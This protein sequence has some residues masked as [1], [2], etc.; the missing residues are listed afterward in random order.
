MN[1]D[2][3]PPRLFHFSEDPAIRRFDPRPVARPS[4]R[5]PGREWLNGPLVWAIDS[6][7]QPM[8]LFPRDCPRVLVWPTARTSAQDLSRWREETSSRMLAFVETAW[9]PRLNCTPLYRY[10]FAPGDFESLDDAGMWVSRAAV[11]PLAVEPIS[12]LPARL[13]DADVEL[14]PVHL[15]SPLAAYLDTTF[16][17][18]AIRMRE[19]ASESDRSGFARS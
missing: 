18:S 12:D 2:D 9:L 15:F 17:V 1:G 16:H 13:R 19:A 3:K 5:P 6:E 8:Y 7:H 11:S 10:E 14:R 4:V